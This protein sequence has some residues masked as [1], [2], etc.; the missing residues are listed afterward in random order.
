[1]RIED[2]HTACDIASRAEIEALLRRRYRAGRNAF[3]LCHGDRR[4]PAINIMVTGDLAYVHYF[5]KERHPGF[6]S[7]GDVLGLRSGDETDFFLSSSNEPL[8]IANDAVVRFSDAVRVAQEF[9]T[10]PELP[11]CIEWSEL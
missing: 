3:W 1:M 2:Y 5:P 9:A 7:V 11:K 8:G 10:S 4:F 6:A